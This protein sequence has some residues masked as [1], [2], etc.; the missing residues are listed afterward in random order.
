M[1]KFPQPEYIVISP[2]YND[3]YKRSYGD[4]RIY[5]AEVVLNKEGKEIRKGLVDVN[6]GIIMEKGKTYIVNIYKDRFS[7]TVFDL[8]NLEI[9]DKEGEII[10]V[11]RNNI[12]AGYPRSNVL[13]CKDV[14]SN[15]FNRQIKDDADGRIKLEDKLKKE[16]LEIESG[17]TSTVVVTPERDINARSL[18]QEKT[19]I[20]APNQVKIKFY[21][22][23]FIR[24]RVEAND[25][26]GLKEIFE[27]D[28]PKEILELYPDLNINGISK[29]PIT[30]ITQFIR[31][32]QGPIVGD[33]VSQ[34]LIAVRDVSR[35]E[36]I[37]DPS[38]KKF[39]LTKFHI[40]DDF[41][42]TLS[43]KD[44]DGN[45]VWDL[46][47]LTDYDR[48]L[49]ILEKTSQESGF[50]DINH[51]GKIDETFSTDC[52]VSSL[53]VSPSMRELKADKDEKLSNFCYTKASW[54]KNLVQY[55]AIAA[56]LAIILASKGTA[57][58]LGV[59]AGSVILLY[60]PEW[61]NVNSNWPN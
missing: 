52:Q 57:W 49:G 58:H 50:M 26:N 37:G 25:K 23:T 14:V 20:R 44:I 7:N 36:L 34:N 47:A 22:D 11:E 5:T 38:T 4:P 8:F 19:V 43:F 31:S 46:V 30:I 51:D 21:C 9:C 33:E 48:G 3:I 32:A 6:E 10:A 54:K 1:S 45:G 35:I 40:G 24:S 16:G 27:C 60:G 39:Y 17:R 59:A 15:R 2:E 18:I 53:I 12:K 41:D 61:I 56:D 55:T 29:D 28:I 13:N 42:K